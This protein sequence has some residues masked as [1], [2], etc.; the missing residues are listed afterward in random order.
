MEPRNGADNLADLHSSTAIT[1]R[2][3]RRP[4]A[5]HHGILQAVHA[6]GEQCFLLHTTKLPPSSLPSHFKH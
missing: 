4:D 2:D 3:P 5:S 1:D 6:V